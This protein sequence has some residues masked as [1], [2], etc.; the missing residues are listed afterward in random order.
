MDFFSWLSIPALWVTLALSVSIVAI[1]IGF[2]TNAL[3]SG[4]FVLFGRLVAE[5]TKSPALYWALY[6][7]AVF[8][9]GFGVFV[10]IS[11]VVELFLVRV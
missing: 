4:E 5:R 10:A 3:K 9:C 8:V 1:M 7:D 11:V 2:M 6:A